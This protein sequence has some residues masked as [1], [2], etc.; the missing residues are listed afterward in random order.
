ME[1]RRSRC[2][3]PYRSTRLLAFAVGS[4]CGLERRG[5]SD[6]GTDPIAVTLRSSQV[7]QFGQLARTQSP[8][9][10]VLPGLALPDRDRRLEP[11]DRPP[12]ALERLGPVGGRDRHDDRDLAHRQGAGAVQEG[13]APDLRPAEPR[14]AGDLLQSG[15]D[16]RLV[17]LVLERLD[18]LTV[19]RVVPHRPAE[20][21]DGA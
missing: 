14:L 2:T 10:A 12:D 4:T 3:R 7:A 8:A 6:T 15:S 13:Q 5:W 16:E 11:V 1:I 21:I 19:L 9:G 20:E 18:P 17:G